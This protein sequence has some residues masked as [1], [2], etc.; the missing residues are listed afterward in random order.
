M[1]NALFP[2][3]TICYYKDKIVSLPS[4]LYDGNVY[5]VKTS[6]S[7]D[8]PW[9]WWIIWENGFNG[10]H[11]WKYILFILLHILYQQQHS[12]VACLPVSQSKYQCLPTEPLFFILEKT[13]IRSLNMTWSQNQDWLNSDQTKENENKQGKSEGNLMDDLKQQ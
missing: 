2:K 12:W 9:C 1:S 8:S 7:W 11:I 13:N 5:T 6:L 3:K 10:K 4:Y